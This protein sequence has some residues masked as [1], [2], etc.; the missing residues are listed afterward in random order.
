MWR[1]ACQG[2]RG[3]RP[4][5]E[6]RRSPHRWAQASPARL[7]FLEPACLSTPILY[8][9]AGPGTFPWPPSPWPRV[10]ARDVHWHVSAGRDGP[11][12]VLPR[13]LP[14]C[15]PSRAIASLSNVREP[16]A[17]ASTNSRWIAS[18]Q[19]CHQA[20]RFSKPL[21]ESWIGTDVRALRTRLPL[22]RAPRRRTRAPD[23]TAGEGQ[24]LTA[25]NVRSNP[26]PTADHEGKMNGRVGGTQRWLNSHGFN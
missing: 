12:K 1:N 6:A 17:S 15:W 21:I 14:R 11:A 4:A 24:D 2:A 7:T 16:S 26:S 8:C 22:A 23:P 19:Q 10:E 13:P 18:S 5:S 9:T 20:R 25:R 3:G